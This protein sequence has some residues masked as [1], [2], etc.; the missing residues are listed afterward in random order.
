MFNLMSTHPPIPDRIDRLE[1]QAVEPEVNDQA[2]QPR[3]E[4]RQRKIVHSA[5]A[6]SGP[7]PPK[8]SDDLVVVLTHGIVHKTI[9]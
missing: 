7:E 2:E 6:Q 8:L 4:Q 3:D 9:L 5:K 1:A